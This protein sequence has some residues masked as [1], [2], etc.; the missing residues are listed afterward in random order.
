MKRLSQLLS[1]G[2]IIALLALSAVACSEDNIIAGN[3][4]IAE[5]ELNKT[6][7][8]NEVE[9]SIAFTAND[10]WTAVVSEVSTRAA[11]TKLSW[12]TLTVASGD[13]GEVK[14]PFVVTK[15]DDEHYREARITVKCGEKTSVIIVHQEANPDAVHTM[16]ISRIPDY[17]RFY[18]PGT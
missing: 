2:A 14:M 4:T 13:A 11:D 12:L 1:K 10:N 16:D 17:D 3:I 15:N 5:S 18:C 9:S 6:I 7:A 8:W